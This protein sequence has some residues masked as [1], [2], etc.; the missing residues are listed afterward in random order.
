M[1][2]RK[3]LLMGV[4]GAGKSLI[5]QK[6]ANNLGIPFFDGDD[7]H[8]K[9]NVKKMRQGTPLND[10]DRQGWLKTLNQLFIEK[11]S[12][13]L[14][15][16][17]LKQT[18]RNMLAEN[19]EDMVVVYLKGDFDTIWSRHKKRDDHYF[20]G[21]RMLRSQF[22]TLEEPTRDEA[23]YID[24]S[25]SVDDVVAQVVAALNVE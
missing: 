3:I 12:L 6:V 18:Y 10:E 9:E 8:P 21:E 2:Q 19:N 7:Y 5:G 24:I 14:A 4:S 17:A 11:Q 15:C 25:K 1:K 20:T 13:V 23:I 16:S 22:E